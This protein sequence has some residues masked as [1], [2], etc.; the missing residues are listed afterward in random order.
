MGLLYDLIAC[1]SGAD[2]QDR[3]A[4]EGNGR[5]EGESLQQAVEALLAYHQETRELL[6]AGRNGKG[7]SS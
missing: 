1:Q 4:S 6:E 3:T 2:E 5:G 7:L